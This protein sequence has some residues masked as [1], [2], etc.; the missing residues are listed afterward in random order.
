MLTELSNNDSRSTEVPAATAVTERALTRTVLGGGTLE[1]FTVQLGMLYDAGVVVT[2]PEGCERVAALTVEHRAQLHE[3]DLIDPA[4][5]IRVER[6]AGALPLEKGVIRSLPVGTDQ[7][8]LVC[9]LPEDADT[10]QLGWAAE[11]AAL[12]L[13]RDEARAAL[14]NKHRGDFLRDLLLHR[15]GDHLGTVTEHAAA[16]GWSLD[17]PVVVLAAELDPAPSGVS[18]ETRRRWQEQ[19]AAS[20]RRAVGADVPSVD[21]SSEVVTLVPAADE[22]SVRR[23]VAAVLAAAGRPFSVGASRIAAGPTELADAYAQARRALEVGRRLHGGGSTTFFD[24][25]GV[26]RLLALIPERQE[27]ESFARDVLG[28]LAEDSREAHDLRETLHVLLETNFNVADA[29]RRQ[30][31]HYNTTRFRLTRLERQLGPIS[32]DAQRRL[33]VALALQ[34]LELE[35]VAPE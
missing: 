23:S 7:G 9:L 15:D 31:L 2:T 20:W 12:L 32:T 21:F 6:L 10:E 25:L 28:P 14:E 17:R 16:F 5:R 29:A 8:R 1:T 26:H 3:H 35:D 13:T 34:V 22:E 18:R 4:G 19:F 27:V 11:L 30:F 24:G 33:D